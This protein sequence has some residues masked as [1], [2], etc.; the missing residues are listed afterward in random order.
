MARPTEKFHEMIL[1]VAGE[2]QNDPSCGA[3]KLNKILFYADFWAYRALGRSI[4]GQE[5]QKLPNGPAPRKILPATRELEERGD[6]AWAEREYHGYRLKK[7]I[8][9]RPADLSVFTAREI[10]IIN[11][12][13]EELRELNATEVSDLSHRFLGWKAAGDR[14]T[15]PYETVFIDAPRTLTD[16]EESWAR[17]AVESHLAGQAP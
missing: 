1:H 7:L 12:V 9:L 13:V 10:D 4:S 6:C 16:G 14:E 5:Y 15:I 3:T 11:R 2:A 17:E 8:A